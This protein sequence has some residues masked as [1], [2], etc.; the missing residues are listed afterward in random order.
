M[1]HDTTRDHSIYIYIFPVSLRT[2]E[3]VL[4]PPT[5]T[6]FCISQIRLSITYNEQI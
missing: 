1:S 3:G 2:S 5:Y 6:I 4:T